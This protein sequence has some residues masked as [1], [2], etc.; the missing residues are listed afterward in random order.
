MRS[1]RAEIFA[2]VALVGTFASVVALAQGG[3]LATV[4]AADA[5]APDSAPRPAAVE[6]DAAPAAEADASAPDAPPEDAAPM[7]GDASPPDA[8]REE[9]T[10]AGAPAPLAEPPPEMPPEGFSLGLRAGYALPYGT[11]KS[12]SL[13]DVIPGAI[14]IGVDVGYMFSPHLYVGGYFTY[15]FATGDSFAGTVCSDPESSCSATPIRLGAAVRWHFLP[16]ETLDP[17]AGLGLG[18]EIVN[19]TE[20][21]ASGD[22]GQSASLHGFEGMLQAGIDYKPRPFYGIGPFVE[23]SLGHYA[24]SAQAG[25]LHGWLDMGVRLRTRL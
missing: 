9:P 22:Q 17:W 5:A 13:S 14:H 10:D 11:A 6:I 21:T 23:S 7:P 2:V 1:V 24:S 3:A 4:P 18:Y 15:G 16:H 20:S 19:V 8:A 25:T 12:T